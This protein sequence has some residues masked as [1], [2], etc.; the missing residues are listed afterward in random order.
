MRN[1][2]PS[3]PAPV[4]GVSLFAVLLGGC[5]V[6]VGGD[7][8]SLTEHND[9]LRRDNLALQRQLEATRKQITLL[10]GEVRAA[11]G[12]PESDPAPGLEG[13]S[14]PVLAGL[15]FGRYSG[16]LDTDDDGRDDALKLYLQP[17][18]QKGRMLVVAGRLEVRVLDVAADRDPRAL[19][20]QTLTPAELDAAYRSGFTGSHYTVVLPLDD[21]GF[22]ALDQITVAVKLSAA[23]PD[24]PAQASAQA[25]YP[26]RR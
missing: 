26:L 18:D 20:T 25:A 5:S 2:L 4:L 17:M 21:P 7:G 8:R 12:S 14:V 13:A 10:Q 19:M 3:R 24:G 9:E 22:D 15:A 6:T 23:G 1:P 16:P 11:H